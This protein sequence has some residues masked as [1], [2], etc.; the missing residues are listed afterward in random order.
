MP[1]IFKIPSYSGKECYR[2]VDGLIRGAETLLIVSPY[3]DKYYA[4]FLLKNSKGK[5]VKII[6]SSIERQARDLL[7]RGRFPKEVLFA[8]IWVAALDLLLYFLQFYEYSLYVFLLALLLL[9][10]LLVSA[11]SRPTNIEMRI[12]QEFVHVK[13]YLGGP[14]AILGSANL[15]YKGMHVNVEHIE[16]IE[17]ADRIRELERQFWTLWNSYSPSL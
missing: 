17:N 8:L 3:I 1:S 6:S 15:T 11:S 14:A 13:M 2:Y 4:A 10:D 9:L 12:P 7:T 5:K 16:L